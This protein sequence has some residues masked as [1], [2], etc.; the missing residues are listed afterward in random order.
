MCSELT[1]LCECCQTDALH[2]QC[3]EKVNW[4]ESV[5]RTASSDDSFSRSGQKHQPRPAAL[6]WGHGSSCRSSPEFSELSGGSIY[7]A[8]HPRALYVNT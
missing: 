4:M 7:C 6:R 2:F 5:I 1:F 3:E 8:D